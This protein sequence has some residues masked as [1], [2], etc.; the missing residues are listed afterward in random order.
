MSMR[1]FNLLIAVCL[2][3][4]MR[5]SLA[6]E[7]ANPLLVNHSL[8]VSEQG[9][10]KFNPDTL[11]QIW[12]SLNGV[13]TFAPVSSGSLILVGSTQGLYALNRDNGEIAWHIEKDRNIFSP[14]VSTQVFAGS[15]HGELYSIDPDD[16][17]IN[18]RRQF[19][20]WI[21]SP[22]V[23]EKSAML[24]SG[25]QGHRAYSLSLSD[26]SQLREYPTTQELVFSPINLGGNQIAFNL[27]DGSTLI[28]HSRTGEVIGSLSGNIQP[29]NIY[30]YEQTIYRSDRAGGLSAFKQKS[31]ALEWR[32]SMVT[33]D[34][35]MHPAQPGFLLLSDRDQNLILIDLEKNDEIHR[36]E[37]VGQWLSPVQIDS[38]KIIYFQKLMQPPWLSAVQTT[39]Q[40]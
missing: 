12:S 11:E 14:V 8:Y 22:A 36:L 13:E 6:G 35:D 38:R 40:H 27:F 25:G 3:F 10:F 17:S 7:P 2:L 15:L 39:A 33:G 21:Y 1:S 16:G 19:S 23:E 9:V 4:S 28:V 20:G 5:L 24:W 37:P 32:R 31:L 18:W 34:L 30:R 29:K 26:G